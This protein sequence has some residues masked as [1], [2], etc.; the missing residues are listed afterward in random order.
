MVE[1]VYKGPR[2]LPKQYAV[3]SEYNYVEI[4]KI[5]KTEK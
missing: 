2:G 1:H 4:Y 5:S 3:T